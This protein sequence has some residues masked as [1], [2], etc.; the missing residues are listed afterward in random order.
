[1][2]L[3][4]Y[5]IVFRYAAYGLLAIGAIIGLYF[6]NRYAYR[7][8][9]WAAG[10]PLSLA[11]IHE[12]EEADALHLYYSVLALRVYARYPDTGSAR[13]R[14][15]ICSLAKMQIRMV[16]QRIIPRFRKAG[17]TEEADC[18]A[19]RVREAQDLIATVEKR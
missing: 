18:L 10:R 1:M 15:E 4:K 8:G 5:Q 7:W 13:E 19:E 3:G 14:L 2:R 9:A 12:D 16:E 17:R 11:Y 6:S